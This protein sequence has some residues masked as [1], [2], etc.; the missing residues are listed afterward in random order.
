MIQHL[1]G[2]AMRTAGIPSIL[3][4]LI[5]LG[6]ISIS[7]RKR[8]DSFVYGKF[9]SLL[10]ITYPLVFVA[11]FYKILLWFHAKKLK[12]NS[13]ILNK[14]NSELVELI[15]ESSDGVRDRILNNS[16]SLYVS[17]F[18]IIDTYLFQ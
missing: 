2:V 17:D 7:A 3:I 9:I 13:S 18:K 10:N 12:H 1:L 4:S 5:V 16:N 11:F 6:I 8:K 14:R 15:K